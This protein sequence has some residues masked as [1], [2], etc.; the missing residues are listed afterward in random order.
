MITIG[1]D[2]VAH[3]MMLLKIARLATGEPKA[4]TYID[5]AGYAALGGELTL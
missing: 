2:D 1:A 4:D 5:I 3:L